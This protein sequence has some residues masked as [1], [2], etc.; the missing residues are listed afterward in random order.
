M[1]DLP[2]DY[3][4]HHGVLGMKWGV[5]K[6]RKPGPTKEERKT[7]KTLKRRV[8]AA[9]RNLNWKGEGYANAQRE[10]EGAEARYFAAQTKISLSKK[11]RLQRIEQASKSLRETFE[12]TEVPRSEMARAEKLYNKAAKDMWDYNAAML[13]KYGNTKVKEI[14]TGGSVSYGKKLTKKGMLVDTY[15]QYVIND[16]IKTGPTVANIPFYGQKWSGRYIA[17]EELKERR[18]H[19]EKKASE[20]Y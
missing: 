1:S 18:A 2:K 14:K 12:R 19:F 3:L 7:Q 4:E 8:A 10:L 15:T 9:K 20:Q 6:D 13:K 11:K 16:L 17:Q 5:R